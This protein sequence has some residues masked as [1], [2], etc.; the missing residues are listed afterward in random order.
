MRTKVGDRLYIC[1][2]G[3]ANYRISECRKCNTHIYFI[4][5][6]ILWRQRSA[7]GI[8]VKVKVTG[9]VLWHFSHL[10]FLYPDPEGVPSFI[11]RGVARRTTAA[12]QLAKEGTMNGNFACDPVIHID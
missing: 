6:Y 10:G 1:G 7:V 3:F 4:L 8:K 5:L 11:S 9:G 12:P 2:Q